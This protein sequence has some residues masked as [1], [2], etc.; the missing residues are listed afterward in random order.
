MT[1]H[2]PLCARDDSYVS[3]SWMH[4][5]PCGHET[6]VYFFTDRST[7]AILE[8]HFWIVLPLLGVDIHL[9]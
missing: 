4:Y 1:I 9:R 6:C 8:K 2:K 5:T 3:T 7:D